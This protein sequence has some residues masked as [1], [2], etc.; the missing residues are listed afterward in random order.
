MSTG[1]RWLLAKLRLQ[2]TRDPVR[3]LES[4]DACFSAPLYGGETS[5]RVMKTC[6]TRDDITPRRCLAP[7]LNLG[8]GA[9]DEVVHR[10]C[11]LVSVGPVPHGDGIVGR[12]AVAGDQHVRDLP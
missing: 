8:E 6:F 11:P 3:T 1:R 9:G 12:L 5:P 7:P 10:A 2:P 4:A